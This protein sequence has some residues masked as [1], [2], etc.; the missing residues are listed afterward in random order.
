MHSFKIFGGSSAH[1]SKTGGSAHAVS[2]SEVTEEFR[3]ETGINTGRLR[4]SS[5]VTSLIT[6]AVDTFE[7][8]FQDF[9][10]VITSR[11]SF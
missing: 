2:L 1:G 7:C 6:E 10:Q 3:G 4:S 5:S 9:T 8:I 11:R